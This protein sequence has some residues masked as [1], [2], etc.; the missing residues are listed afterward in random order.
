MILVCAGYNAAVTVLDRAEGEPDPAARRE[1]EELA[2]LVAEVS[3]AEAVVS[4]PEVR[5]IVAQATPEAPFGEPGPP[6][7]RRSPLRIGFT[8]AV[9]SLI[10]I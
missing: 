6:L 7:A 3:D 10:H 2:E 4:Y 5:S 8:A 1:A 9:L